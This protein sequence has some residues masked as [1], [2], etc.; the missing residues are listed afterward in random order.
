[1]R[2]YISYGEMHCNFFFRCVYWSVWAALTKYHRWGVLNNRN[3]FLTILEP[4]SLRSKCWLIRFL[5]RV[6]FLASSS[7]LPL[8]ADSLSLPFSLFLSSPSLPLS[9][10]LPSFLSLSPLLLLL[11]LFLI[12]LLILLLL[13]SD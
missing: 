10:S 2:L 12:L 3:L 6:L 1:M 11:V 8:Q 4:G 13:Q 5:V 9:L 7:V